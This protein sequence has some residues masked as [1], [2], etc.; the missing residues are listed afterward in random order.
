MKHPFR[1]FFYAIIYAKE[2]ITKAVES[3]VTRYGDPLSSVTIGTLYLREDKFCKTM[4]AAGDDLLFL[5]GNLAV[6]RENLPTNPH[7]LRFPF[8]KYSSAYQT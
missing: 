1:F 8:V 3:M 7:H 6:E 2:V 4:R 5:V